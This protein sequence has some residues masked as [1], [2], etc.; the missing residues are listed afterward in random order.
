MSGSIV[1][2][3]KNMSHSSTSYA[4]AT[5]LTA[6]SIELACFWFTEFEYLSQYL[7]TR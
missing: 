3:K 7:L 1:L 4:T 6:A 2:G 5:G